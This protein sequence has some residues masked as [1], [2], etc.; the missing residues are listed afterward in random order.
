MDCGGSD[1]SA[2]FFELLR[3]IGFPY[4]DCRPADN[5]LDVRCMILAFFTFEYTN[6]MLISRFQ[7]ML[8]HKLKEEYCHLDLDTCG[9]LKKSFEVESSS[10]MRKGKSFV[11]NVGDE[12]FIA[13]SAH[14]HPDLFN[15]TLP[16]EKSVRF[17]DKNQGDPDDPHDHIYL[18]DTSRKY[19]KV[20]I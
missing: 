17:M 9:V 4:K 7:A 20:R 16:K 14:F 6:M 15:I 10:P 5:H 12:T 3:D 2:I 13:A 11:L 1:I 8:L 18:T 19:T